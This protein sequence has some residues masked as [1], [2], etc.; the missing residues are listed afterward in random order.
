ML[1]VMVLAVAC[2]KSVD[3]PTDSAAVGDSGDR[4]DSGPNTDSGEEPAR[5]SVTVSL[6]VDVGWVIVV[7]EDEEWDDIT[8]SEFPAGTVLVDE[9]D[10]GTWYLLAASPERDRCESTAPMTFAA[11][12][13]WLWTVSE[14]SSDYDYEADFFAC[15]AR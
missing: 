9:V 11:G 14:F 13:R 15:G 7:G 2:T 8:P 1:S 12:D 6:D 3:T 10:P 5:V 4:S